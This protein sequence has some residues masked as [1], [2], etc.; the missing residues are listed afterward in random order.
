M[1]GNFESC[2]ILQ[3]RL[4]VANI[5]SHTRGAERALKARH[6]EVGAST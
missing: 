3:L 1:M 2:E 4:Q 6:V 5:A